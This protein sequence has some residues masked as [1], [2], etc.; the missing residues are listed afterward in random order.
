MLSKLSLIALTTWA[1]SSGVSEPEREDRAALREHRVI[2]LARA[3]THEH[4]ADVV[5]AP[6]F[7]D[8]PNT[9]RGCR[10]GATPEAGELDR[11]G[12]SAAFGQWSWRDDAS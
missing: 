11:V 9:R 1:R 3:L 2:N 10:V 8:P 4:G 5:L 7:D 6:T 12:R